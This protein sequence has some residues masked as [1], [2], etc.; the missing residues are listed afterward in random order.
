MHASTLG[1]EICL[2]FLLRLY[3]L[4]GSPRSFDWIEILKWQPNLDRSENTA[5]SQ[6]AIPGTGQARQVGPIGTEPD[7]RGQAAAT[8]IRRNSTDLQTQI[9]K[10][11]GISSICVSDQSGKRDH[12][13]GKGEQGCKVVRGDDEEVGWRVARRGRRGRRS[14]REEGDEN[15]ASGSVQ[16]E[17]ANL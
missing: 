13:F 7:R 15:G 10:V 1:H 12:R 6:F 4:G 5:Y 3:F 11:A 2:H 14:I 16:R 17:R 8:V 9:E